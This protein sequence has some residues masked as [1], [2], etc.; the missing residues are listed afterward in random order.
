M[1]FTETKI[2]GVY[3]VEIERLEDVRGF[4]ARTWDEK[5]A[6][7][8]GLEGRMVQC[9]T[10]FNR[11]AGTLRGM[12]FQTSPHTEAKVVRCTQGTIYD[13]AVDLRH[14]SP[15]FTKWMSVELSADNRRALY[16]PEGCAHGFQSL[17]DDAEV[18]YMMSAYYHPEAATGVRYD[19]PAFG[20]EWPEMPTRIISETD[21]N[22]P[23]WTTP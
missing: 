15:T 7:E 19:D 23:D 1:K 3:V 10:G 9:S 18:L 6:T 17:T 8:R 5:E 21:R 13:V 11:E 2:P 14:D 16:I 12:H 22:W 20:I 4:F